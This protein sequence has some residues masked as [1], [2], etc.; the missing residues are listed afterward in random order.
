MDNSV[1]WILNLNE[2][3]MGSGSLDETCKFMSKALQRDNNNKLSQRYRKMRRGPDAPV[4]T[5]FIHI[6]M[7]HSVRLH[8]EEAGCSPVWSCIYLTLLRG[9]K[10]ALHVW[11]CEI[12]SAPLLSQPLVCVPLSVSRPWTSHAVSLS[13]P[14]RNPTIG[15]KWTEQREA[16]F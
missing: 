1:K 16:S 5:I 2:W 14:V 15:S 8:C 9:R 13:P 11:C 3:R 4:W 6:F 7:S 10:N 12:R